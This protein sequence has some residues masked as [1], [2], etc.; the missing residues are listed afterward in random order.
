MREEVEFEALAQNRVVELA[1]LALPGRAG[2]GN[3]DIDAAEGSDRGIEGGADGGRV[4]DVAGD[5]D[6][7]IAGGFRHR[8]GLAGIDV[9]HDDMRAVRREELCSRRADR[10]GATGDKH[11]LAGQRLGLHAGELC[12]LQRPVF[13]LEQFR[14]RQGLEAADRLGPVNSLDP[15][16][17]DVRR[18]P[19]ILARAPETEHAEARHQRQARHR[20]EH[21]AL[22]VVA[23]IVGGEVVGVV[24]DIGCDDIAHAL[25]ISGDVAG[26][27]R[28]EH[29]RPRLDPDRE[30]GRA[31]A[32]VGEPL[33]IGAR[34]ELPDPVRGAEID[35]EAVITAFAAGKRHRAAQDRRDLLGRRKRRRN[36]RCGMRLLPRGDEVFRPG[37]IVDHAA[38]GVL[39]GVAE[40][41]DAVLVEDQ[42]L[43]GRVAVENVGGRLGEIEARLDV[44]HEPHLG[45]E[46]LAAQL[47]AVVLV[48]D[49]Q[50]RRRMGVV[51]EFVRQEG[52]EKRLDRR[53]GRAGIDQ[54]GALQ[55]D[56]VLVGQAFKRPRFQKRCELDRR[57]ARGL[58]HRHV[59]AAALDAQH[60]PAL[61]Q[62]I[63]DGD[64]ARRIAAAVEDEAGIAAK[65]PGGVDPQRQ[66]AADIALGIVLHQPL[67]VGVVPEVFHRS[68]IL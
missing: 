10:A 32:G 14:L 52:V 28:G 19:R 67:G 35:D 37:H 36:G 25:G 56:H 40:G 45:A 48:D 59:P 15:H 11:D 26:G 34:Q 64:L 2:V 49:R 47:F 41:E 22:D 29:H 38:I 65:Q 5:A 27:G 54:I 39:G 50:D 16:L 6:R 55:R 7:G 42:A 8:L 66:I 57:Q 53:V 9:G 68:S 3:D 62:Q 43:D 23:G 60:V 20:I 63:R 1:D 51:D 46:D 21:R 17:A 31:D 4:G 18:D 13:Q 30:V 24:G 58:D 44:G 33:E 12:L 61:A